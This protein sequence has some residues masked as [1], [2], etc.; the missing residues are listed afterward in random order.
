M[1]IRQLRDKE[2]IEAFL[3]G[4]SELHVYSIG[5]LD[6]FFWPFTRWLGWDET[7]VVRDIVLI[8]TGQA[9]PTVIGIS[10]QPDCMRALLGEVRPLLPKRFHAHLSPGVEEA[11]RGSYEIESHGGHYKMALRDIWPMGEIDCSAVEQLKEADLNALLEFYN[12]SYPGNWFDERM[13]ETKQYFG[14]RQGGRLVSVAGVHV[15]SQRYR[16]AALG[17]I[18]TDPAHRNRGYGRRVTARLCQALLEDV[19]HIGLNVKADNE[20]AIRCYRSLGFEIIASYGE[21][22]VGPPGEGGGRR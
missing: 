6:D 2:R 19:D 5:D 14:L 3:R 1:E 8:Y 11:L 4:N 17:N 16:V 12:G 20:A 10:E 7:G 9:L 18:G 22:T 21:Y 15:Y 13:L